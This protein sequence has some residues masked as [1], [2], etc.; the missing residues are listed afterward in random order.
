[1]IYHSSF[2]FMIIIAIAINWLLEKIGSV[3]S[4]KIATFAFVA[5]ITVC[6]AAKVIPRNAQWK[7]DTTLFITDAET[8]PYSA[9]VNGN[10]GKAYLDLADKPEN[11]ANEKDLIEKAIV[12]LSRSVDVHK[13][14]V[15][16][17][18]NLGVAY[19]KLKDYENARI[20]WDKV[21]EIYPNNPFLKRNYTVLAGIYYNKGMEK[22]G[23]APMEA[24]QFLEE[25]VR[26]DQGNAE[27]WYNL[28]GAYYTV[29]DFEKARNA[30]NTTL[31]LNP[32]KVEAQ[33]GLAAL[34]IK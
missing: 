16:G 14:Y 12:H 22:G 3:N 4:K 8:V 27:Y 31:Q 18:L 25:A 20:Q 5:L 7:N 9:L 26:M 10:A 32:N 34:P 17:Y 30:W 23:K 11:K 21:A 2:G 29:K 15:N 28:G 33:Q 24:I 13:A 19:Y 6:C 1:M